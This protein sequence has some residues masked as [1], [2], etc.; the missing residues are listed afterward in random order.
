M[1]DRIEFINAELAAAVDPNRQKIALQIKKQMST[2]TDRLDQYI[3]DDEA[4]LVS[5]RVYQET[6]K[7]LEWCFYGMTIIPFGAFLLGA[8]WSAFEEGLLIAFGIM[9]GSGIARA[10]IRTKLLDKLIRAIWDA[11][12]NKKD[13]ALASQPNDEAQRPGM[14]FDVPPQ[15]D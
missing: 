14:S 15:E 11:A 2:L 13:V 3:S 10:Y 9:V 8:S 6:D 7:A 12:A 5:E 1:N 4:I